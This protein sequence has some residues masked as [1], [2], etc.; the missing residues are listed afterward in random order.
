MVIMN[1]TEISEIC[2]KPLVIMIENKIKFKRTSVAFFLKM[3]KNK[4]VHDPFM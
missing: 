2:D 1:G 3:M 4:G